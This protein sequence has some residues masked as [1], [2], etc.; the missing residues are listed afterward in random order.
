[1]TAGLL[2]LPITTALLTLTIVA[3][4]TAITAALL[5]LTKATLLALTIAALLTA[6]TTALLTLAIA[7]LGLGIGRLIVVPAVVST[8]ISVAAT[9]GASQN[10]AGLAQQALEATLF[11]L[12]LVVLRTLTRRQLVARVLLNNV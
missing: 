6:V 5:A 7:R 4:L 12:C 2:A 8:L 11:F 1:V 9:K 3:L 10:R